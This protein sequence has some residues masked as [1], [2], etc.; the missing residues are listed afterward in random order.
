MPAVSTWE[1]LA[2][3]ASL[4]RTQSG[5]EAPMDHSLA[6]PPCNKRTSGGTCMSVMST[7]RRSD[8]G[9]AGS[10]EPQDSSTNRRQINAISPGPFR[11]GGEAR[12]PSAQENVGLLGGQSLRV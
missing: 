7:G 8:P 10:H 5:C 6:L 2:M 3:P 12:R 9:Y 4:D 1:P 11:C